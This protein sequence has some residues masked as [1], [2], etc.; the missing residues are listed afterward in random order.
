MLHALA[1]IG[2]HLCQL[3]LAVGSVGLGEHAHRSVELADAI[4]AAGEVVFGA[5]RSLEKAVGD[6]R[7][8]KAL[9]LGALARDDRGQLTG[10]RHAGGVS[11][12]CERRKRQQRDAK[13]SR[14]RVESAHR[15]ATLPYS[16]AAHKSAISRPK[17][18]PAVFAGQLFSTTTVV[19]TPTRP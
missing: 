12:A 5:E 16:P 18:V 4:D 10:A 19:P 3:R 8:G 9:L 13:G 14:G 6:F 17:Q 15:H 1:D 2:D 11:H 7:V